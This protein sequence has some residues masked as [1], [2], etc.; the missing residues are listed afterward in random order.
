M[1]D[2]GH[3]PSMGHRPWAMGYGLWAMGYGVLWGGAGEAALWARTRVVLHLEPE[4]A[5]S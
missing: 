4:L 3:G 5:T 1:G 2:G